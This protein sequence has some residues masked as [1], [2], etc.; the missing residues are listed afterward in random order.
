MH[1]IAESARRGESAE[2][3]WKMLVAR[4]FKG[5]V[6]PPFNDSARLSAGLPR[7]FYAGVDC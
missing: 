1:F 5:S 3:L 6:K 4:H 2:K 7:S